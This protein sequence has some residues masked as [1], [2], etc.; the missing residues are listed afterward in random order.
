MTLAGEDMSQIPQGLVLT[1]SGVLFV[2]T[3]VAFWYLLIHD[4]LN[5]PMWQLLGIPFVAI[6]I[7]AGS[8]AWSVND[9]YHQV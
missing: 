6:F 5:R 9:N 1:I 3:G 4:D 7:A 8:L 2:L